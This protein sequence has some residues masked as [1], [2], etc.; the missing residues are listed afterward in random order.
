[1]AIDLITI[2][3]VKLFNVIQQSQ[4]SASA[5]VEKAKATRGTGKASLPAP[6]VDN[7][8]QEKVKSKGK[9]SGGHR[10]ESMLYFHIPVFD[11]R[12]ILTCS[13]RKRR[14][15]RYDS[16]WW[17]CLQSIAQHVI[18]LLSVHWHVLPT[19]I[20]ISSTVVHRLHDG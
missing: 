10:G 6:S 4:A 2:P 17:R 8:A 18:P 14:F 15:F 5:T 13:I 12:L 11:I 16:L 7:K 20:P 9:N 3:V 1:M 19:A